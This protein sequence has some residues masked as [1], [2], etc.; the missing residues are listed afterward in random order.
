MYVANDPLNRVDPT[1][2]QSLFGARQAEERF[3][4]QVGTPQ[5]LGQAATSTA[6]QTARDVGQFVQEHPGEIAMAVTMVIPG[7]VDDAARIGATAA[8]GPLKQVLMSTASREAMV[9]GADLARP[10]TGT[11]E[12]AAAR[13]PLRVTVEGLPRAPSVTGSSVGVAERIPAKPEPTMMQRVSDFFEA[14][15]G[16]S[17]GG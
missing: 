1:G 12:A 15:F 4:E 6:Q 5:E 3:K 16:S 7:Q 2:L 8:A 9:A 10:L 17:G 11:F 14:F 13:G